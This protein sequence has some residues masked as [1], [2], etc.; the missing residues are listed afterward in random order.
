M[1]EQFK[2]TTNFINLHLLRY[3]APK[4]LNYF[5]VF[6]SLA[7]MMLVIQIVTGLLLSIF[8]KPTLL[9]AFNS[10]ELFMRQVEFG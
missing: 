5:W 4:S 9:D 3:P 2:K 6:G 7:G 8:Y 10:T 1:R